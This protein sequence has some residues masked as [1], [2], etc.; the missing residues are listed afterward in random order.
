LRSL[1]EQG[2]HHV[3]SARSP[4]TLVHAVRVPVTAARFSGAEPVI[5]REPG[6][7]FGTV[8]GGITLDRPSTERIVLIGDWTD[9]VD[10][11][12]LSA[13]TTRT[14][15]ADTAV[16]VDAEGA[17]RTGV[18]DAATL[19]LVD[20]RR[21]TVTLQMEA[22]SRF[23][24]YFTE[25]VDDFRIAATANGAVLDARGVVARS[26]RITDPDQGVELERGKDFTVDRDAGIV[27]R[28][29]GGD[30]RPDIDHT[31]R[32]IPLPVSRSSVGEDFGTATVVFP[33]AVR[34]SAPVVVDV[35]PAAARRVTQTADRVEVDHDGR[36]L[37][38]LLERPWYSSGEEERLAVV[39][40]Q[41]PAGVPERTRWGRD[42]LVAASNSLPT[43]TV[44]DFAAAAE[45][46]SEGTVDVAAHEVR[47]DED[48]GLWAAD[49]VI[50]ADLGERPFVQLA[51][52]RYQPIAVEGLALSGEV[53]PDPVRLGP[54]RRVRAESSATAGRVLC[55][56][57]FAPEEHVVQVLVQQADP[58]IVDPDLRW[59]DVVGDTGAVVTTL[60]AQPAGGTPR[61][62]GQVEL[63]SVDGDLRLV[64]E[65]LEPVTRTDPATGAAIADHEVA[66]RETIEIPADWRV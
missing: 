38:V 46:V 25:Q 53:Q 45:R 40:D 65:D 62:I 32:Y 41:N 48:R 27:S 1:V 20:T 7:R 4:L 42:P 47:F 16:V 59:S 15:R 26:V 51:L 10:D 63:P 3:I 13:P 23:S 43:P 55:S 21:H 36:V 34:P 12:S 44:T 37:R 14:F 8:S 61:H 56:V 58:D 5:G 11:V 66:Y 64:F 52:A 6:R 54:R 29:P 57:D 9:P 60:T 49:V 17:E 24:R 30:M 28:V 19:D 50:G 2:R 31:V 39:L 18:L 33:A 35:V 22:F